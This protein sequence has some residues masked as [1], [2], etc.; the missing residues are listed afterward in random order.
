ML[1]SCCSKVKLVSLAEEF[2]TNFNAAEDV[3]FDEVMAKVKDCRR[4]TCFVIAGQERPAMNYVHLFWRLVHKKKKSYALDLTSHQFG[5]H[6]PLTLWG[7]YKVKLTFDILQTFPGGDEK[8]RQLAEGSFK[9][10]VAAQL[11]VRQGK[12]TANAISTWEANNMTMRQLLRLPEA[13]FAQKSA[14]LIELCEACVV[15]ALNVDF[16]EL[17]NEFQNIS[18]Y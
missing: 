18:F 12:A 7:T 10:R 2:R 11:L 6:E 4:E 16:E 3:E 5:H 15:R 8:E 14:E 13:E 1:F 17:M 9:D